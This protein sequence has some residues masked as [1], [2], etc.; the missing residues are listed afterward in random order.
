MEEKN[1]SN[2]TLDD[3]VFENRNKSYGSYELRTRY[4]VYVV[5]AFT[6]AVALF[7]LIAF[8]PKISTWIESLFG[9]NHNELVEKEVEV[10]AELKDIPIEKDIPPPPPVKVEPP[11]IE[12]VKFLPP[13]IKP[14][15][16]VKKEEL[17]PKTNDLD[18]IK[19]SSV[20]QEG[21]KNI[22]EMIEDVQGNSEIGSGEDNNIYTYVGEWPEFPGGDEARFKFLQK[23]L[24][25]PRDA[26]RKGIEGRVI[27]GFTVEKT[28]EIVDVKIL[29]GVSE[30]MDK[31]AERVV[32]MM[33]KWKPGKNNGVPVRTRHKIF[34]SFKLPE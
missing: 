15:N 20:T 30:S 3:L 29:K 25:Y 33:P 10:I 5:R 34:I 2:L 7:L 22:N 21:D 4:G 27:V 12:S 9:A 32:K 24:V 1:L 14:D 31:E 18:S 26:E 11:K 17:P 16:E 23:N 28:G 8:S 13:E 6:I 19:I